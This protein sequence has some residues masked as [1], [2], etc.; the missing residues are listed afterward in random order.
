MNKK[1]KGFV[2]LVLLFLLLNAVTAQKPLPDPAS[3]E[4]KQI[5]RLIAKAHEEGDKRKEAGYLNHVAYIYLENSDPIAAASFFKRS[6][7]LNQELKNLNAVKN[8]NHSLGCAGGR[9]RRAHVRAVG[10]A[11]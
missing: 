3:S 6:L 1:M 8:L 7:A 9:A 10:R 11:G 4:V 5:E 2:F